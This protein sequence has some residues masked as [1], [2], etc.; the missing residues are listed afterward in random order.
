MSDLGAMFQSGLSALK[1]SVDIPKTACHRSRVG[2]F[3]SDE[4]PSNQVD[5]DS[6]AEEICGSSA[7]A[8]QSQRELSG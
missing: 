6:T 5:C 3:Q 4:P 7:H 8:S 1:D 2:R